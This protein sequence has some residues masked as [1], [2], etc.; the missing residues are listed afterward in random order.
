[1]KKIIFTFAIIFLLQTKAFPEFEM[2]LAVPFG[3]S[4]I[5]P[6]AEGQ[7][8]QMIQSKPHRIDYRDIKHIFLP[9][10]GVLMQ[11]GNN[12]DLKNKTGVTSISLLADLGYY[13]QPFG[14]AFKNTDGYNANVTEEAIFFNTLDFG[15]II[16][17][18][19]YLPNMPKQIP[20][21]IGF[22]GGLKIPFNATKY[23]CLYSNGEEVK[24]TMSYEDI[25]ETFE[26]HLIPYIKLTYDTYYYVSDS[27]ALTIG[28]NMSYNFGMKYNTDKLNANGSTISTTLNL[29]KYA[30]SSSLDIGFTF[31]ISFGRQNPRPNKYAL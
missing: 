2:N 9:H 28:A 14:A 11:I 18:N 23:T 25:K 1:M 29:E 5:F 30:Y 22:G 6:H 16:K 20:F 21:S 8:G 19:I 15:T 4:F 12:F 24:E 31:G 27:I 26:Q 13:L 17:I 10:V 3:L 7:A